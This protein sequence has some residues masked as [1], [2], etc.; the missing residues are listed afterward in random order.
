[1][2]KLDERERRALDKFSDKMDAVL[3]NHP[4]KNALLDFVRVASATSKVERES[5]G[6]ELIKAKVEAQEWQLSAESYEKLYVDTLS[7][8]GDLE[9][10]HKALSDNFSR[11]T[12]LVK[13]LE[14]D[15]LKKA[16][17][18]GEYHIKYMDLQ[19]WEKRLR[20]RERELNDD[21]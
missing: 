7:K 12:A 2:S 21:G 16:A 19:D 18:V 4:T 9:K 1:M 14:E 10:R 6:G 3:P 17:V 15:N 13:E 5:Y 8:L 20:D 11:L